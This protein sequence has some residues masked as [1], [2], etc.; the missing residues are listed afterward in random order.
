MAEGAGR[1]STIAQYAG[2]DPEPEIIAMINQ[3]DDLY[4]QARLLSEAALRL[5]S[6]HAYAKQQNELVLRY[7]SENGIT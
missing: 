4:R 6:L 3:S 5:R 7:Q 2:K 1:V